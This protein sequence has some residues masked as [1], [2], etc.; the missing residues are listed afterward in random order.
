MKHHYNSGEPVSVGDTVRIDQGATG[1]VVGIIDTGTYSDGFNGEG[2]DHY[3]TG[4]L[5]ESAEIG[6]ILYQEAEDI[7][8]LEKID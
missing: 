2:W 1:E 4:L 7:A 6:L 8:K 5:V 3:G